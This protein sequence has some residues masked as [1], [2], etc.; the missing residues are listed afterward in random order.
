MANGPGT[1]MSMHSGFRHSKNV[2]ACEDLMRRSS[3]FIND[4]KLTRY[5]HLLREIKAKVY[6]PVPIHN[7]TPSAAAS[8]LVAPASQSFEPSDTLEIDSM[9]FPTFPDGCSLNAYMSQVSSFLDD[10][11]VGADEALTGWYF[12]LFNET[13]PQESIGPLT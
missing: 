10:S 8:A 13:Q 4:D 2:A 5:Q 9:G 6:G 3:A 11:M 1:T 7:D 12:S